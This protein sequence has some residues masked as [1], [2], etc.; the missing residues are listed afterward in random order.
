MK[1]T[2]KPRDNYPLKKLSI[3]RVI[4]VALLSRT[5]IAGNK[6][7]NPLPTALGG[8]APAASPLPLTIAITHKRSVDFCATHYQKNLIPQRTREW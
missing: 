4:S 1:N 8:S 3:Q 2:K 5:R 7:R 6:N